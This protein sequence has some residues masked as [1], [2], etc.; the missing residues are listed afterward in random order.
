MTIRSWSHRLKNLKALFILIAILAGTSCASREV[1]AVTQEIEE[2]EY[3]VGIELE[4]GSG[5]ATIVSPVRI[6]VKDDV[7]TAE[8]IWTSKNYDYM[9]V[10][11]IR[12]EN[13][14]PG[15]ASTFHV[16]VANTTEPLTVIGDTVA[17]STPHEITYT[18]RWG[19]ITGETSG[20]EEAAT[21]T[22]AG[23]ETAAETEEQEALAPAAFAGQKAD[24]AAIGGA[25]QRAGFVKTGELIPEYARGFRVASY[26]DH[27]LISIRDT[28]D[29][30]LIPEGESVPEG[31]PDSVVILRK[32]LDRVY[33]VSTSVM[34][35]VVKCGALD[36]IRL[37]GT[38]ETDWYIREAAEAMRA[39]NLL[40]A[41]KY[42]A[43]DYERILQEDCDLAIENTMIYHEPAV[44]EK[45][46]EFGI[47][48]LVETSSYED[49]PL[50]RLEWIRLYGVLFDRE[51]EADAYYEEQ[52]EILRPFLEEKHDTGRTVAFFH[53]TAGGLVNVRRPG[54]YITEMIGL[55]G[56][57]YVP[58]HVGESGD[59]HSS[60]N[61]QMEDFY[62]QASEADIMIYNSTIGG[63]ITSV[64]EL[65]D[66][67]ALFRD[68]KAV[69]E[70]RVYCTERNFFQ[71][72][73]GVAEFLQDLD[74]VLRD[75]ERDLNYL[76]RLM[77]SGDE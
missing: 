53:V 62:A 14:N 25:L 77:M 47:P 71:Q 38:K 55:A 56:G 29:Y 58:E 18:I 73:S 75:E 35:P 9:I 41:G 60:M 64:D 6:L 49:H 68:F 13:E 54:D 4:G 26:G 24:P 76:N 70:G 31:L 40:Y 16:P 17:M 23:E 67:D 57:R 8:L 45:L 46:T 12:Y 2:T 52:R 19:D 32:P 36:R 10:D 74:A 39:G 50:G 48:V 11:G 7:R 37:S 63:E 34:D 27:R 72:T 59:L 15:G 43:P 20:Q 66:K 3:R 1:P 22:E 33:L 30:L 5:K 44:K 21:G 42:R 69:R 61:M 51:A 28:G 65:L